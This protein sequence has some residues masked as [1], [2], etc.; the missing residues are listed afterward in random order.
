MKKKKTRSL[1]EIV[2][3]FGAVAALGGCSIIR[4]QQKTKKVQ[5]G[6]YEAQ[7]SL[8]K[9]QE[10]Q[11]RDIDFVRDPHAGDTIV[12][13][14]VQGNEMILMKAIKDEATGEM[15]ANEVLDAA[16][17]TARFRNVAERHGKV[18]LAFEVRVPK[19]M[20]D[21]KWQLRFNPDM[22]ILQDSIRLDPVIIT[23]AGYRNAQLRGYQR[24]QRFLDSIITD[25]TAFVNTWQLEIWLSRNL[26]QLYAFKSDTTFVSEDQF[27]SMFGV[28]ERE[29]IR[30]Y[31]DWYAVRRNNERIAAKDRM[32]RRYVKAPII[33]DGIRLDTVYNADN[34]D[35]IYQYVQTINTRPKLRKVDIVLSGNIYEQDQEVYTIPR[36]SPLTFY[37]S[38]LSA[39]ADKTPRYL[40]QVIGRKVEANSACFIEFEQGKDRIVEDLGDNA[41]EINRIKSNIRDVLQNEKFDL[42][43]VTLASYAS[44]EG[45]MDANDRLSEKRAASAS[46][47]F[48]AYTQRVVDSLRREE[49][50]FV[51]VGDSDGGRFT[52]RSTL[53]K[54]IPFQSRSAGENW[55]RLDYLVDTDE[56][57]TID[58]KDSYFSYAKKYPSRS[59]W[60]MREMAMNKEPYYRYLRENLYPKTRVVD[61]IFHLHRKG[62]VKDTV[63]TTVL[64]SVYMAGVQAMDDR[65]FETALKYL[66][67]YKDYNTAICYVALDRNLSAMDILKDLPPT[68]QIK[69]MMALLWSRMGDD[70]KAVNYYVSAC[71]DEH[72]YVSRGNLDP[73]IASLIRKYDLLKVIEPDDDYSDVF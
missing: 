51:S 63:H 10:A 47:F 67:T 48:K 11:F 27:K 1:A 69:Y 15:V 19:D 41:A 7:L 35:F 73:E 52:D 72:T 55:T 34:G 14:D 44:P 70:Q 61:V 65:D 50:L 53:R 33:T 54:G 60:D 13:Q 58:D 6:V 12:V 32:Y 18:D 23:G 36:T 4:E 68:A 21:S 43:S 30:H 16:M 57:M 5:S 26:P 56:T 8:P 39:F 29:A 31:T 37:I 62:M 42:D 46:A 2:L 25:S 45:G 38:S 20:M 9:E 64:D 49:G 22:Y 17:V 24:Y 59:E 3:L 40:T 66:S 28:T 71:R